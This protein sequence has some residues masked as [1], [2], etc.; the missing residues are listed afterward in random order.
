MLFLLAKAPT[1]LSVSFSVW[2]PGLSF[3]FKM[4]V[5]LQIPGVFPRISCLGSAKAVQCP[6]PGPKIGFKSL[7]IPC[8]FPVCARGQP[9]GSPLISALISPS[10]PGEFYFRH[11][12]TCK[13]DMYL[14]FSCFASFC[15]RVKHTIPV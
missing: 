11:H 4:G 10:L 8:Y 14:Q 12:A 15:C 5:M 6:L 3:I 1:F 9:P 2:L 7:Q 13:N